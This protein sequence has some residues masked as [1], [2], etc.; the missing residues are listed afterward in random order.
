LHFAPDVEDTLEFTAV[1]CNTVPSASR[2][3][4]DELL[5]IPQLHD[6]LDAK[7]YGGARNYSES[8]RRA[9][10]DTR[11]LLRTLWTLDRNEL[12]GAIN[13]ILR[14]ANALPQLTRHDEFDWH[15]HAIPMD[16][17]LV[18]RIRV[19]VALAL[20]DVIRADATDRLRMCDAHDCE[21]LLIDLSRNGSRR[22]CSIRCG[23]RMNMIA[24]RERQLTAVDT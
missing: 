14:E 12:A 20:V 11:T 10:A 8:E 2:T 6:L 9:V 5:T 23:N 21:G 3:G 7:N 15:I 4:T 16:A 13:V 24:Y 18:D 19:E 22:F 1:L 17:P